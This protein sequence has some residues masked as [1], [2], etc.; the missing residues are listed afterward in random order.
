MVMRQPK[1]GPEQY[2]SGALI[3][4]QGDPPDKFYII[5]SGTVEVIRQVEDGTEHALNWLGPGDFFGEIGMLQWQERRA[6]VRAVTDVQVMV[7]DR[8]T[9]RS[10]LKSSTIAEAEISETMAQRIA[11]DAAVPDEAM[12]TTGAL[13]PLDEDDQP[14]TAVPAK[15]ST[16]NANRYDS[17]PMQFAAGDEIVRQGDMADKFYIIVEGRVEVV[18]ENEDGSERVIEHLGSGD[19]FGEIGLLEGGFRV[20]TVRALT[21]VHTLSFNRQ[22][23]LRWMHQSPDSETDIINTMQERLNQIQRSRNT[24]DK[25]A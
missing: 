6:S 10:W 12:P 19:Y 13:P 18:E 9:F 5:S 20:A 14:E 21:D 11:Q 24:P 3:F 15:P 2:P 1:F 25:K 23:F 7:M 22:A 8:P 4:R 16:A 17:G